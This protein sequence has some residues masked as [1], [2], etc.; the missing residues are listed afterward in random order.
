MKKFQKIIF[1]S[2]CVL[3]FSTQI[4]SAQ[5]E[6]NI[7]TEV[8][9]IVKP[10]T[11]TI[12]DAFKIKETPIIND[13]INQ[14][15]KEV[16]YSIFSVPVASTFTPSK[17]KATKLKKVKAKKLYD[18]YASLGLGNYTTIVGEL[19]SN[20][21]LSRT[22]NFGAFIKHHS[23]QGGIKEVVLNDGFMKNQIQLSYESRQ[24]EK[25]YLV[26]L[27][28]T[29]NQFNWYGLPNLTLALP[30]TT[31]ENIDPKQNYFGVSLGGEFSLKDSFF[32]KAS[33]T[34]SYT[35][36]SFSSSEINARLQPEFQ[37]I[38]SGFTVKVETDL[39]YLNGSFN[40]NYITDT[41]I[42]YS[43][44]NLGIS[45]SFV[46]LHEGFTATL[47]A[48]SY[49]SL[50]FEN[51]ISKLYIFPKVNASY[52]LMGETV[53]AYAGVDG[54]LF[55]NTYQNF[56]AKNPYIS[57]TLNMTPTAQLYNGFAGLKGKLSTNI[58]YNIRAS[59]G[60]EENKALFQINPSKGTNTNLR[61]YEYG[62]SFN[63][64]YDDV[65]TLSV[66]GEIKV[67]VNDAFSL[68]LNATFNNYKLENEVEVWNLPQM[69]AS[70]FSN[71]DITEKIFGG[72]S[73]FFVGKRKDLFFNTTFV[74]T[75]TLKSY[76]DANIQVGYK[77]NE[78]LSFFIKGSNLLSNNYEKWLN[79]KVQGIQALAGATY[80]FDW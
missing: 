60:K 68:G 22:D 1:S 8:V 7:G 21:Q 56:S 38:V 64:I 44:L 50:D 26:Q 65:N 43:F 69:E 2:F 15:K 80:K 9:N 59:Y 13:S 53:I 61:A 41:T 34:L 70:L 25:S 10:Y 54:G 72:V 51:S 29:H 39:D 32:E 40:Q 36:D 33:L 4:L 28:A 20:L 71:F 12:S 67:N 24:K 27:D 19:Y 52:N 14:Q 79:Y 75:V 45:P 17:G 35:G 73:L 66:F 58:A 23:S 37:F 11:P 16:N 6:N 55:Q 30:Q 5:E 62:N 78:R 48:T 46:F 57:P 74:N 3:S 77:Y 76:L 47:G 63:V 18:N 49:F 31:I 42:N